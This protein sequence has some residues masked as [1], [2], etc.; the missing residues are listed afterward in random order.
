MSDE[1][2]PKLNST[3][4]TPEVAAP[5]DVARLTH[6]GPTP[7]HEQTADEDVDVVDWDRVAAT[8]DFKRLIRAKVRFVIPATVFFI[9]YYFTLPVLVGYAPELMETKV[10]GVVNLAYLFALSQF[11]MAWIIAWLYVRAAG[12]FDAMEKTIIAKFMAEQNSKRG[13]K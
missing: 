12:R 4:L 13:G 3:D 8:E 9:V 2:K 11:F 7:P 6:K 1:K 5:T 10:L